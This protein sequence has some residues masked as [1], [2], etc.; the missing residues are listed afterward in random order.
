VQYLPAT[1]KSLEEK[2]LSSYCWE[3]Y[4][5]EDESAK[6]K[7]KVLIESARL[8]KTPRSSSPTIPLPPIFPH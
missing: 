8:E 3:G 7:K 4:G 6:G 1:V 5:G 2:D